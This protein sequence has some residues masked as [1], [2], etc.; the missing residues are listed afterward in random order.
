MNN[1]ASTSPRSDARLTLIVPGMGSDHCAG[2]VS[3]SIRRL[4]GVGRIETSIASHRV[5]VEF[6]AATT[7]PEAIRHAVERAGYDVDSVQTHGKDAAVSETASEERYL[8]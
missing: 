4:D 1:A 8:A 7:A 6:D 5:N 2:L 3:E